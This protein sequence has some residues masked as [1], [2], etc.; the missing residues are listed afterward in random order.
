M[1]SELSS[2]AHR[3]RHFPTELP[4]LLG[5][6]AQPGVIADLGAGD[7]AIL[8]ALHRAGRLGNMS[9][10]IDLSRERLARASV[11]VPSIVAITRDATATGL[12]DGSV[13]GVVCSQVIEHV[14][15]QRALVAEVARILRQGG[16]WYI[17]SVLRRKRSFWIYRVD[18]EWRLDPTHVREYR[19]VEEFRHAVSHP[20]LRIADVVVSSFKFPVSHLVARLL[21]RGRPMGFTERLTISPPG[22]RRIE[23]AGKRS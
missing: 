10:A 6:V 19:S 17:G 23:A 21:R 3:H 12:A 18:G 20:D 11:R 9:Y 1:V 15:N 22:F 2:Y 5:A 4:P 13:D 8:E 16:W 7:G 14:Q